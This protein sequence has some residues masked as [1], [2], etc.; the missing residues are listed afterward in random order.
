MNRAV[1]D[2]MDESFRRCCVQREFLDRFYERFLSS[3][4]EIR[5]RFRGTD[6]VR[7]RRA[8]LASLHL[9]LL[10]AEDEEKGPPRYLKDL[11]E[12][13]SRQRLDIRPEFY[14]QWR[15]SLIDTVRECDPEFDAAIEEAWERVLGVGI[16]Y[17]V[18]HY[19]R[20]VE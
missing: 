13:H 12:L 17:L 8:L 18:R 19:D 20:P 11:A 14:D 2:R 10:A 1:L 7:Q 5:D 3:S 4:P 9:I 15:K 16:S 6:F